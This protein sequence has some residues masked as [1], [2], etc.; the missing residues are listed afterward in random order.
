MDLL[1]CHGPLNCHRLARFLLDCLLVLLSVIVFV[2]PFILNILDHP[3]ILPTFTA[4]SF[5]CLCLH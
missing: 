3:L 4:H 2:I 5:S 1:N